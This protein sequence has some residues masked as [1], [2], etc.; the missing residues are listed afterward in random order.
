ME[1]RELTAEEVAVMEELAEEYAELASCYLSGQ[2]D[3]M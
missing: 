1:E 2:T 3:S